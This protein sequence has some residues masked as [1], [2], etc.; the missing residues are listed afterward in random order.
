MKFLLKIL[1]LSFQK[2]NNLFLQKNKKAPPVYLKLESQ[3]TLNLKV[4][5]TLM[6]VKTI[7]KSHKPWMNTLKSL[8]AKIPK[9]LEEFK[10]SWANYLILNQRDYNNKIKAA[11]HLRIYQG[12]LNHLLIKYI[13]VVQQEHKRL[14]LKN[15]VFFKILVK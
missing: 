4:C 9:T 1:S 10:N 8:P 2:N 5:I 14:S 12:L 13:R 11:F 15:L 6:K 7:Q 3:H